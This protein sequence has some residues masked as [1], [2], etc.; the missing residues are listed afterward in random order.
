MK[1]HK[2]IFCAATVV[3]ML[4]FQTTNAED[5]AR[6]RGP[7]GKGTIKSAKVATE[8]SESKNIKWQIDLP[9]PGSSSPIVYGDRVYITC[10]TGYG[11]DR[12]NPGDPKNLKRH[13][14]CYDRS[15]GSEVW[16]TTVDSKEAEDPYKGFIVEHGYASS[17]PITDGKHIFT[18]FGKSGVCAF[19]MKGNKLWQT[20]LGTQSDPYKW[21]GGS[22]P[23][24]Y[25]DLVI[26]NAGNVGRKIVALNQS[27]GK[28][29]WSLKNEKF[30]NCWGT[31]VL[32]KIKDRTELVTSQPGKIIGIDPDTGKELWFATSPINQT[33]CASLVEHDGVVFAE[34]GRQGKA[35]AVKCGGSGDVSKTHTLWTKSI[36]S[37]IGTPVVFDDTLVWSGRGI[38]LGLSVKNGEEVFKKRVPTVQ[39]SAAPSRGPAGDYASPI[40]VSDK[41]FVSMRSG[42]THVFEADKNLPV[43]STNLI[44]EDKPMFN[45]TP[46]VSDDQI[47]IRSQIKLYCIA[48]EK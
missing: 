28:E 45:A 39:S 29:K 20:N 25:K 23:I 41:L 16:R 11:T 5:W 12:A 43:V 21:G 14:I 42:A 10:Y 38:V 2:P 40:V 44:R 26:V 34:G 3:V 30:T 35:L 31:P 32:V 19:D 13:L 22:S 36:G 46:A 24:L 8:W 18:F 7:E 6:F 4:L 15:N 33:V 47:F 37:G 9:G 27:D 48:T 17:T 1:F